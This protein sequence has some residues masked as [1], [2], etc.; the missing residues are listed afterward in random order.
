MKVF[1][2]NYSSVLI[3][4]PFESLC[5]VYILE[6]EEQT[7]AHNQISGWPRGS[8]ALSSWLVCQIKLGTLK[9]AGKIPLEALATFTYLFWNQGNCKYFLIPAEV[10][11]V[12]ELNFFSRLFHS[13]IF[14]EGTG[15]QA[16]CKSERSSCPVYFT[17]KSLQSLNLAGICNCCYQP[18]PC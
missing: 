14:R 17:E 5:G 13:A 2:L 11:P 7:L 3:W 12:R 8:K 4:F 16:S 1:Q 15:L 10:L 18:F 6:R 9:H